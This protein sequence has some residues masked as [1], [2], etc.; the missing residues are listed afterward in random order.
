MNVTPIFEAQSLE[1]QKRL[2]DKHWHPGVFRNFLRLVAN[3]YVFNKFL[4]KG[5]FAGSSENKTES[6]PPWKF[7]DDEFRRLFTTTLVRKNYFMQVLFLGFIRYEEGLPLE[8]H[9]FIVDQIKASKTKL[10][11]NQ[12]NLLDYLNKSPYDFV[13]L[14]D[15]ISYLSQDDARNVLKRLHPDT[16]KGSKMVIRSFLKA[17]KEID[18]AKWAAKNDLNAWAFDLDGTGVYQF[19]IFEKQ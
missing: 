16:A 15:T 5:H 3:E 6:R 9:R 17:P 11:Y 8:A 12:G 18:T 13:S 4:Y 14:S 2:Y 19:H 7:L 1:E 10:T